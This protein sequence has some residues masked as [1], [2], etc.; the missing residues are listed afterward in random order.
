MMPD[1]AAKCGS[2]LQATE[3]QGEE[4]RGGKLALGGDFSPPLL[5]SASVCVC[6][7]V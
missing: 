5:K 7:C 1:N 6:E 3:G 2:N 4:V